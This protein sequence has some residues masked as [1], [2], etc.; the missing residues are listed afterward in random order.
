MGAVDIYLKV[1]TCIGNL[2]LLIFGS[3]FLFL[4]PFSKYFMF[5][6]LGFIEI[7]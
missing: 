7:H 4:V 3:K 1:K 2:D 6:T 5:T